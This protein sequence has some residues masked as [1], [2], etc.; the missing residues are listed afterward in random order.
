M[1][2]PPRV[3]EQLASVQF[4]CETHFII[5]AHKLTAQWM[6]E[7]LEQRPCLLC[8]SDDTIATGCYVPGGQAQV[9]DSPELQV[10]YYQLCQHCAERE[11]SRELVTQA[12]ER[13]SA[14]TNGTTVH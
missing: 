9:A 5:Y 1:I 2:V 3:L 14:P 11:Y 7:M 12:L 10:Q 6:E 8:D 13:I 4:C